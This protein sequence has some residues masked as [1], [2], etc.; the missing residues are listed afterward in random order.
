MS[1][2]SWPM[3]RSPCVKLSVCET[4]SV[5]K[6]LCVKL[7][8]CDDVCVKVSDVKAADVKTSGHRFF[9]FNE[10]KGLAKFEIKAKL[11]TSSLVSR[12][13]V[14]DQKAMHFLHQNKQA[15]ARNQEIG[16]W[17]DFFAMKV[18]YLSL[19]ETREESAKL[20]FRGMELRQR[21]VWPS[22]CEFRYIFTTFLATNI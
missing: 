8:G 12:M 13:L 2:W 17:L 14:T 21:R 9:L 19:T 18:L 10:Y 20:S 6:C 22:T 15:L 16:R 7:A 1:M 3:W 11:E 4:V 5:W